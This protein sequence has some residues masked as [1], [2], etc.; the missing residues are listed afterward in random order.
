M[1]NQN[2]RNMIL[3]GILT[4]T[5]LLGWDQAMRYFY[6][7]ANAPKPAATASSA[8]TPAAS[9]GA[10]KTR[11]G[12]L[13]NP[14]DIALEAQDIKVALA[15]PARVKIEAPGLSGSINL[16]GGVIDDLSTNRHTA[17]LD[18]SQGLQRIYSP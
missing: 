14:A 16:A 10:K 17:A 13:T 5:I 3:A 2:S 8:P 11:E 7:Q 12:G 18:Q 15:N 4:V 9:G 6:P 1:D